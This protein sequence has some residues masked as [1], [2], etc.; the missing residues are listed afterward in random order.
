MGDAQAAMKT[1]GMMRLLWPFLLAFTLT[2]AR[3]DDFATAIHAYLQHRAEVE[4]RPGVIAIGVADEHGSSIISF[5]KLGNGTDEEANG[6][7]AFALHSGTGWFTVLLLQDMLHR[8]EMNLDDPVAN[9]LPSS[10]KVPSYRG[11][12]ITVRH[13]AMETSG[14]PD[15]LDKLDPKRADD[16]DADFD[17]E[18]L[19]ALISDY[20]LSCSPGAYYGHGLPSRFPNA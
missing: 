5:G 18:K 12:Q 3:A 6:D 20:K 4:G 19:Y 10:V 14:L 8:G 17:V 13:L 9:Y 2:A 11:Q 15:F 16:P 1:T 7:S